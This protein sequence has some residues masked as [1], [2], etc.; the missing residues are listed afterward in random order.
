MTVG[1]EGAHLEMGPREEAAGIFQ[2]KHEAGVRGQVPEGK[3]C[4]MS[5]LPSCQL[6]SVTFEYS[7]PGP[8]EGS[9]GRGWQS[10]PLD[11]DYS[12]P[13]SHKRETFNSLS[14]RVFLLQPLSPNQNSLFDLRQGTLLL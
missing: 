1:Q 8:R 7:C 13:D 2:A 4:R 9:C 6:G 5:C 14:F 3:R 10:H 11:T 12:T